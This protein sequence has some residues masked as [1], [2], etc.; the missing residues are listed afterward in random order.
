M[1]FAGCL[2]LSCLLG[3]TFPTMP[4]VSIWCKRIDTFKKQIFGVAATVFILSSC[5]LAAN[6]LS[7]ATQTSSST[8]AGGLNA[9]IPIPVAI[10]AL[11][12]QDATALQ[13]VVEHLAVVGLAP[14]AGMQG[15][16]QIVYG[17]KDLSAYP[18][19]LSM[20]SGNRFRLDA[21]SDKGEMSLRIH[22]PVGK[23]QGSSGVVE[24]IP[25]DAAAVGIF[26]FAL[27]RTA[28][29]PGRE[30][31]LIDHGLIN[32]DGVQLHRM[33]VEIPSIGRDPVTKSRRTIAIDLYFDPAS[34]LLIKSASSS[35]IA[36]G[37]SA[38]FLRVVTYSDY[39]KIGTSMIPFHY[40]E[41]M[42]GQK[43]WALQLSDVKLNPAF[44]PTYFQ[45]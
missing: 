31:S 26:P 15:T 17:S 22:G 24:T 10:G 40:D 35:F 32:E 16:G 23:I 20:F 34:H 28:H 42:N 43:Y 5:S 38:K 30:A 3:Y 25:P 9:Q 1:R 11:G 39:R 41:S 6:P 19:T 29:F 4:H 21:Q 37:H 14:W 27:V 33:T 36:D 44:D 45:F 13:E 7:P 18:A 2:R 8:N 12:Q